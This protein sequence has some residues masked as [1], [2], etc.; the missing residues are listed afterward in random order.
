[1]R[2]SEANKMQAQSP[3]ERS[4]W[5]CKPKAWGKVTKNAS[6][7]HKAQGSEVSENTSAKHKARGSKASKNAS[8]KPKG[9]KRQSSPE[10]A[11][12][13]LQG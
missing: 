9:A 10:E 13:D 2:V 6:A 8:P 1:M 12:S 11:L 4:K 3:K 5:E 7:K